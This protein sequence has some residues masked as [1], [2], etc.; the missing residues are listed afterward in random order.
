MQHSGDGEET[1]PFVALLA[2]ESDN[3]AVN[4]ARHCDDDVQTPNP[5]SLL[6]TR[7]V[8]HDR[9]NNKKKNTKKKI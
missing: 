7:Y 9:K 6:T 1:R 2:G 3:T 4:L 8:T 5:L